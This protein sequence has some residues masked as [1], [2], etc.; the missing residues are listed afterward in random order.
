MLKLYNT[1]TRKIETF[2]PKKDKQVGIYVC[3]PTVYGP[4]HLGHARTYIV[5]DILH[6]YL[7][8]LG[9]K[10][11]FVSNITDIH[12]DIINKTKS[13]KYTRLYFQDLKKLN[14]LKA[15][16]YP[17]VSA[18]LKEIKL[19]VEK[20]LQRGF[21]Y[22]QGDSI[23][24]DV[25]RFKNYGK[26]SGIKLKEAKTG[27]RIATDKYERKEAADFALWKN[28]PA[29]EGRGS[30]RNNSGR[31]GWHIECSAMSQKYLGTQF[32]IHGG[33][34]DLIFPHHENEIAQSEAATGK[35]PFV[36]YWLHSGTLLING[37]KMSR[38][39]GNYIELPEIEKKVNLDAL[40]YLILTT[41][42]Q[43]PLDFSWKAL[44]AANKALERLRKLI[45]N[46][47]YE[48]K[49]HRDDKK[50]FLTT[51]DNNL[52]TPKSL[53]ILWKLVRN[54][55]FNFEIIKDFEKIFGLK[56][57]ANPAKAGQKLQIPSEIKVLIK[58]RE[59]LRRQKKWQE[60][61][62]IR[63]KIQKAGY[64]IKDTENG[65]MLVKSE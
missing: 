45:K 14:V 40:R 30:P 22:K 46:N 42:W 34:R 49:P 11:K 58:Q 31:P 8:F 24:F 15:D 53:A 21:A 20:L 56:L 52:D 57:I 38:S 9:Y 28:G 55:N 36:K 4:S 29:P 51:L 62:G 63:Q 13:R 16:A 1:L 25:S 44:S 54:S 18:N 50:K 48:A 64:Q 61:D 39:L 65:P 59:E 37:K 47:L 3:G 19:M 2:K 60:A 27:T 7:K 35:K 41:H 23:Y 33:S 43:N 5:F 26:L 6:R 12:D 32:D 10:V 17:K